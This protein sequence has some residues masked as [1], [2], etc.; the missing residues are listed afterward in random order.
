MAQTFSHIFLVH[1]F[2]WNKGTFQVHYIVTLM[3]AGRTFCST[4]G[5]VTAKAMLITEHA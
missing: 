2:G 1:T 4:L 5:Y 3:H